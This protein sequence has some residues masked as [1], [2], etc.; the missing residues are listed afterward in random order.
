MATPSG[1]QAHASVG[2]SVR[3][4]ALRRYTP[5]R[6]DEDG[7][8]RS[9]SQPFGWRQAGFKRKLWR[10]R[11]FEFVSEQRVVVPLL[12]VPLTACL[13]VAG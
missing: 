7:I 11:R 10:S 3:S 8:C 6:P 12:T 5:N 2:A 9:G 1:T 13:G 4:R